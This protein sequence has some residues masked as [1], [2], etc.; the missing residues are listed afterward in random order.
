MHLAVLAGGSTLAVALHAGVQ[1]WGA[2]RLGFRLVPRAGWLDAELRGLARRGIASVGYNGLYWFGYL[3]A[4]VAASGV[5]GGAVA[6]QMAHSFCQV[7]IALT[8]TPLATTQLPS[9]ARIH[10][11]RRAAEF[12]AIYR[13][14]IR[15]VLFAVLPVSLVLAVIPTTLASAAALGAMATPA[16]IAMVAAALGTLGLGVIG[17]AVVVVSTSAAYAGRNVGVPVQAM[18]AR[19]A[20]VVA[21]VAAL[22]GTPGSVELLW[23]VGA[24]LAAGNLVAGLWLYVAQIRKLPPAAGRIG[25]AH[26]GGFAIQALSLVPALAVAGWLGNGHGGALYR[27]AVAVVAIGASLAL[28]VGLHRMTGSRELDLLLPILARGRTRPRTRLR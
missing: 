12:A 14:G 8:A 11:E 25:A 15:L 28:Y 1:W 6:F 2:R 20:V 23:R 10:G 5:P 24:T 7:P 9:L 26:V 17:E 18:A 3:A 4:I 13:A 21:G 27:A 16:G 19:L 22:W